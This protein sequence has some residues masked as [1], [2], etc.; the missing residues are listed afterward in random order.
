MASTM[1]SPVE[2]LGFVHVTNRPRLAMNDLVLWKFM[3]IRYVRLPYR[4]RCSL[5]RAYVAGTTNENL[6]SLL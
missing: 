1:K 6:T 5:L 2:P 4:E 3:D